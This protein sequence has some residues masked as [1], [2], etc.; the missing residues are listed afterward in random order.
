MNEKVVPKNAR[1]NE[2]FF[3][4]YN[5]LSLFA[6]IGVAEAYLEQIGFNVVLANELE[7]RRAKLYSQIYPR[8]E[9]I[10]GDI[11]KDS[12]FNLIIK[13]SKELK[14]NFLMATPPCQGMSTAGVQDEND[15]RNRLILSVIKI[16]KILNPKFIFIENVPQ[17]LST[18]IEFNGSCELIPEIIRR[19][20]G[21]DYQINEYVIDTKNY[22]VPQMR[23]RAILLLCQ[24]N[25]TIEWRLPHPDSKIL[26]MQDAIGDL[27][28]LDPFITDVSEKELLKIFPHFYERKKE[29]LL[30]S[31]WHRPPC[32]VKRQVLVMQHTP[33]GKT[34]FDNTLYFPRKNDG[35]PVKGYHNTYKRQNWNTPAYAVT[36]DNRKIS[37]Q[38]NVHPGR[39]EYTNKNGEVIYSDARV[40]TLY[41]I[42]KVSSLPDDWNI[43]ESTSEQ[44]LRR[45]IGEG[46][47]PMFVK[48]VFENL[49]AR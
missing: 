49:G 45:V 44:F 12:I 8:T 47:P 16:A 19:E 2:H 39:I 43:P 10:C 34:A 40:L 14:V 28:K 17:F 24:K 48:K 13:K 32:H 27:P 7:E 37:S 31:K 5:I 23:Q 11:T 18:E 42:M 30:I 3:H 36:M 1:L 38:N 20:L 25:Q 9:V 22:S 29:A 33:T 6:N 46:I 15:E 4:Q 21:N 35:S 26:T 41:E